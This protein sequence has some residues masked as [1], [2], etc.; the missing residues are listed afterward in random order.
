MTSLGKL[1]FPMG[2]NETTS[3]S[4]TDPF[5][6]LPIPSSY[7]QV[8]WWHGAHVDSLIH[9]TVC[10]YNIF[11]QLWIVL[12]CEYYITHLS[13]DDGRGITVVTEIF[14]MIKETLLEFYLVMIGSDSTSSMIGVHN[15]VIRCLEELL[16]KP[17]QWSICLLHC[18]ELPLRHVIIE[19]D[20][21]SNKPYSFSGVIG[22]QLNGSV[23]DSDV[24]SFKPK[25][26]HSS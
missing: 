9:L 3:Q 13:I 20:G 25:F 10:N 15:G 16:H 18:N 17:L 1:E 7:H 19:L 26:F 22:S 23:F 12:L 5:S 24:L 8:L 14:H 4:D 21:S 6:W 11:L 2:L